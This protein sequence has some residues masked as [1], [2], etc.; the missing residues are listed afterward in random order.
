MTQKPDLPD[1]NSDKSINFN[2]KL[3]SD[4]IT[5]QYTIAT[6]I[7]SRHMSTKLFTVRCK[8]IVPGWTD[9]RKLVS[10]NVSFPTTIGN[11]RTVPASP[12]D[13]NVVYTVLRDIK[14]MLPEYW[15]VR[16]FHNSRSINTSNSETN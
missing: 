8:Q 6:W 5:S 12:T 11:C 2:D 16:D 15:T 9:F 13:L 10:L 14:R 7:L 3:S 4:F 1:F